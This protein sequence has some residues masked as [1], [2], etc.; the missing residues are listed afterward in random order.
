MYYAVLLILEKLFLLRWLDKT[1]RFVGHL[2]TIVCF[3]MGWV[4]FAIT[5]FGRLGQYL[6]AM[7]TATFADGTALYLLRSNAVL[8]V[9][10][11]IGCT[12][13]PL[14]LWNRVEAR[15]SDTAAVTLRTV[16]VVVLLL[17]SIAFLVGDSYNPFLYFRF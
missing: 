16:G 11:A 2:Y 13:G 5:D 17:L 14:R 8:L 10:A 12:T 9:L 1:P 7:F 3:I 6:T 15:L 4:L